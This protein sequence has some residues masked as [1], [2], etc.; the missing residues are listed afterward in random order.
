M[1]YSKYNLIMCPCVLEHKMSPIGS[2]LLFVFI[3]ALLIRDSCKP[4]LII[5]FPWFQCQNEPLVS[6]W[7]KK[8]ICHEFVLNYGIF[9][10]HAVYNQLQLLN[11]QLAK[12]F[13]QLISCG[14]QGEYDRN[15]SNYF[16]MFNSI[17]SNKTGG[18]FVQRN[19]FVVISILLLSSRLF[20]TVVVYFWLLDDRKSFESE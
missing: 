6:Y 2:C 5:D 15:I 3:Y 17:N 19:G 16:Q 9:C 8:F 12:S 18:I 7:N 10:T 1:I 11:Q 4:L 20:N 14:E 13:E